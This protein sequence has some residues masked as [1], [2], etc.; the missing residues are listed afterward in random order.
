VS[1]ASVTSSL[2]SWQRTCLIIQLVL[3]AWLA[4]NPWHQFQLWM[5]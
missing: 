4:A 3:L 5:T 1:C 2:P